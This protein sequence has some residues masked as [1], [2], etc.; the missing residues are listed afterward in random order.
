MLKTNSKKYQAN[1][2]N[3]ILSVID[4]E[5]LPSKTMTDK[6][7]VF[8]IMDR[9]NKEY[10][11]EENFIKHNNN[12]TKILSEWLSGLAIN[13]PY[14]YTDIIKL[15]KKLLETDTL[16]N[17]NKI[18]DNYFDFMAVQ[19]FKLAGTLYNKNQNK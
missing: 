9:F 18:I 5:E 17:E 13:I 8:F 10:C 16:K 11:F 12:M 4:S 14:T 2:K 3:Y 6:E 1:F 15:S 19:L 7:K